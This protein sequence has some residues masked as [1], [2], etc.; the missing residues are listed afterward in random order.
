MRKLILEQKTGFETRS[1]FI[2]YDER[3]IEFYSSNFTNKIKEGKKAKF[4]LPKGI[5]FIQGFIYKLSKPVHF[6]SIKLPPKERNFPKQ[7][8]KIV[9][10]ENKKNKCTIFH[11]KGIIFFDN[12]FR[13][14]PKYI[15]YDIYFHELGHQYYITEKYADRYATKRLLELG[16][17]PT[18]IGRSSILSLS[19]KSIDRKK[20]KVKS[21]NKYKT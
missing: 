3:E 13:I 6:D 11:K 1:P 20:A 9:F 5:Y 21:L 7:R 18:Q 16:F 4:N 12:V 8:Y 14:A 10:G 15:L 2:I 17:N 19:S